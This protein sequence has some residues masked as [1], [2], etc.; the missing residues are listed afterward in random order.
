MVTQNASVRFRV[1]HRMKS[2]RDLTAFKNRELHDFGNISFEGAEN[3]Y[4]SPANGRLAIRCDAPLAEGQVGVIVNDE[5]R[6]THPALLA[7]EIYK[8]RFV[9]K[10]EIVD[11]W[12]LGEAV[13]GTIELLV[14]DGFGRV[15]PIG[16]GELSA[17]GVYSGSAIFTGAGFLAA[18]ASVIRVLQGSVLFTGE[19]SLS[20]HGEVES[21]STYQG[22]VSF[23][24]TGLLAADGTVETAGETYQGEV[25]FNGTGSLSAA[26]DIIPAGETYQGGAVF[27]GLGSLGTSV[28][29]LLQGAGAFTGTG[30]LTANGSVPAT[31]PIVESISQGLHDTGANLQEIPLPAGLQEGDLIFGFIALAGI[32]GIAPYEPES[33]S[34]W[35][36]TWMHSAPLLYTFWKIAEGGGNDKLV[37]NQPASSNRLCWIFFRISNAASIQRV[38]STSGGTGTGSSGT[39]TVADPVALTPSGGSKK[40]LWLSAAVCAGG[41]TPSAGSAGYT[42]TIQTGDG[43]ANN[44][45]SSLTAGFRSLEAASENPGA[46]TMATA[47]WRAVTVAIAPKEE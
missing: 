31:F 25:A 32:S 36:A 35:T 10:D 33:G 8:G 47:R 4:I 45:A 28:T 42:N 39:G 38:F 13:S 24:G 23:S 1:A 19:G 41:V 11:L 21:G 14:V 27:N 6:F 46:F 40:Y 7:D 15:F 18:N 9:E 26:A 12:I 17:E 43:V 20:A 3:T 30:T 37:I 29:A 2:E 16:T 34:D 5:L 22:E 44:S